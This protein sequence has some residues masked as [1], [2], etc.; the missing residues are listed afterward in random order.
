MPV[1]ADK[2]TMLAACVSRSHTMIIEYYF[3]FDDG[4]DLA[5][6][7]NLDRSFDFGQDF[8]S[9]PEWTRLTN[10]QCQ[11]CPLDRKHYSHCPAAI[12]LDKVISNVQMIAAHTKTNVRVVTPDREYLKRVTLE[13]GIR[14]LMGLIMA[15]SACPVFRELRPNARTHLPFAS[16]EE[17]VLR[18]CSIYLMKQYLLWREGKEPDWEMHGVI[19]QHKQLQLVNQAFWQRIMTAFQSD[20]NSKALLGFFSVATDISRSM[21]AQLGR[22]KHVFFSTHPV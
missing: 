11:N 19:E 21:D 12:D 4:L 3:S 15:T 20:A 13:E 9:A 16:R 18:L 22:V 8:S 7:V 6:E 17:L 1:Q 5:F 10:N 2:S 14:S